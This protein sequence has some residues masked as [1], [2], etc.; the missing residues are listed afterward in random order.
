MN[1]WKT[2]TADGYPPCD[3]H[4]TFIGINSDGYPACFNAMRGGLCIMET[5]EGKYRQMSELRDWR[6]LDRPARGVE[7]TR[8]GDD[9]K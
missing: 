7:P 9:G 6:V 8:G 2:V 3:G 5:A 1:E 4:T